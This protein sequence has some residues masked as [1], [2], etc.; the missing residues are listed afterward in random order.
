MALE[1]SSFVFFRRFSFL[2][3]FLCLLR[4]ETS[5][6]VLC[7]AELCRNSAWNSVAYE[8]EIFVKPIFSGSISFSRDLF[9]F[10]KSNF[11]HFKVL[12]KIIHTGANKQLLKY[13]MLFV[14]NS[15]RIQANFMWMSLWCSTRR[16]RQ[17][18]ETSGENIT[19]TNFERNVALKA[20]AQ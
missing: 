5:V 20:F 2:F 16:K 13:Q 12:R 10:S 17:H 4:R 6:Y 7:W 14:M 3:I 18:I 19:R 8:S 11:A 15:W 1:F 9:T